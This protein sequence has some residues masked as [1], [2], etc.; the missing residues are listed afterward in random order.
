MEPD[1]YQEKSFQLCVLAMRVLIR[2]SSGMIAQRVADPTRRNRT[3]TAVRYFFGVQVEQ[4]YESHPFI[5]TDE[6]ILLG[7]QLKRRIMHETFA[8]DPA[9]QYVIPVATDDSVT[10]FDY[11]VYGPE[12]ARFYRLSSRG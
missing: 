7:Q 1:A 10:A 6:L 5:N 11:L 9:L 3:G 2:L 4:W 8:R 12:A